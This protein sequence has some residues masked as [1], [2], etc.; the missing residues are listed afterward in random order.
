M[1]KLGP[2]KTDDED[3]WFL[4]RLKRFTKSSSVGRVPSGAPQVVGANFTVEYEPDLRHAEIVVQQLGLAQGNGSLVP[5]VKKKQS[6]SVAEEAAVAGCS[7]S[8]VAGHRSPRQLQRTP[9]GPKKWHSRS[10][11]A[12]VD[13]GVG[14]TP[15]GAPL[16]PA[17]HRDKI[18]YQEL[19]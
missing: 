1:G 2:D 17:H 16:R 9:S 8:S 14:V 11:D 13:M 19:G 12:H 10:A 4:G 18:I 6:G 7:S 3:I 5:M 15:I